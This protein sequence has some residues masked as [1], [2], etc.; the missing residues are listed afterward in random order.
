MFMQRFIVGFVPEFKM[1]KI[2]HYTLIMT[3]LILLPLSCL[4]TLEAL[5][6]TSTLGVVIVLYG[7]VLVV[8]R[9]FYTFSATGKA[10]LRAS[11]RNGNDARGVSNIGA[12]T[13]DGMFDD[14]KWFTPRIGAD[15]ASWWAVI[16]VINML[17]TMSTSSNCHFNAV[18]FYRDLQERNTDAMYNIVLY[19]FGSI[20]T[21]NVTMA[22]AGYFA[23]GV[24]GISH[25]N[26]NKKTSVY[27]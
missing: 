12:W 7:T 13:N 20:T 6:F 24:L 3:A 2:W 16:N 14:F 17:N 10:A 21:L 1:D 5:K 27:D 26:W 15:Q 23:F 19:A 4:K 25:N 9:C 22:V 18:S 8:A 11:Y